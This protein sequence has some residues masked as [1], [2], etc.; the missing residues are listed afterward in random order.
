MARRKLMSLFA[1]LACVAIIAGYP[2]VCLSQPSTHA[3]APAPVLSLGAHTWAL[4][5]GISKYS[6]PMISGLTS[7]ARDVA[8]IAASLEDP[9]L[10][11]VPSS[12][13]LI[14]T[15]EN[16]TGQR[17][18]GAA[19]TFFKPNVKPGDQ[20]ILYLAGHG[21]A[22]GIGETAK[23]YLLPYDVKGL[24]KQA[25][26]ESAVNLREFNDRLAQLPASQFVTFVDACRED[27]TPG[28]G[29][30]GNVLSDT[31]TDQMQIQ[32]RPDASGKTASAVTF[33]ACSVGERAY[34]DPQMEHGVFTYFI[35]DAIKRAAVPQ[36]PDG[37]VDMGRLGTYVTEHVDSW[38]KQESASGD[39]DVEQNPQLVTSDLAQPVVLM[40]VR[41]P[42]PA[43][44]VSAGQP[45]LIV[46]TS[47]AEAT[48]TVNG[49][50]VGSGD[51]Q[52]VI[53]DAGQATVEVSASGY[54]LVR[55]TVNAFAGYGSELS[56]T[57]PPASRGLTAANDPAATTGAV[58]AAYTQAVDAAARGQWDVAE[59]GYRD[60]IKTSPHFAPA[61]EQLAEV[62]RGQNRIGEC[63]GTLILLS[64]AAPSTAHRLSELSMAFSQYAGKGPG[65]STDAES[66]GVATWD[67]HYTTSQREAGLLAMKAA[68]SAVRADSH[69][70][71][72]ER[73]L[74]FALVATD[75]RGSN[76]GDSLNAFRS[77]VF[78]DPAD[79]VNHMALAFGMRNFSRFI[80]NQQERTGE[81][82]RAVEE[83]KQ[84]VQ[85][86]PN[87]Y[88]AHRELA[89]CYHLLKNRRAAE[90]EYVRACANSGH[91]IDGNEVAGA[92]CA[93]AILTKQDAADAPEGRKEA[94]EEASHG[95]W[96]SATDV[97]PDLKNALLS[98]LGA[99]LVNEI[100]N[101][102][103][104]VLLA[105]KE[106]QA[107]L[108]KATDDFLIA[109]G[110]STGSSG[111]TGAGHDTS[112]WEPR[113][114]TV[115][116]VQPRTKADENDTVQASP[117]V[118]IP[119]KFGA[120]ALVLMIVLTMLTGMWYAGARAAEF[121][122]KNALQ[123]AGPG[124]R[125]SL[126]GLFARAPKETPKDTAE[127]KQLRRR[128]F[129][130]SAT[131]KGM[132]DAFLATDLRGNVTQMNPLAEKITGWQESEAIGK[133]IAQVVLIGQDQSG[134]A[135]EIPLSEALH[136]NIEKELTPG[137]TV[138]SRIGSRKVVGG[139]V[140]P[141]W[142][143]A[144]AVTGAALIFQERTSFRE[145]QSYKE[146]LVENAL[147]CIVAMDHRGI[148]V[149]FN[150]A[151][152]STF[153]YTRAEAVGR[154]V[155]DILIPPAMRERHEFGLEQY[156]RTRKA[157]ILG[158][159]I[160]MV[161]QRKGG[162][163]II[164]EMSIAEVPGK[165]PPV[166]ICS[167]R[168][169]TA[170]KEAEEALLTLSAQVRETL[171][172][173]H[174]AKSKLLNV[175]SDELRTPLNA[176]IGYSEILE[177]EL[178]ERRPDDMLPDLKK[179]RGAGSHMLTLTKD[180]LDLSRIEAGLF[181]VNPEQFDAGE[182]V[183]G[184]ASDLKVIAESNENRLE[185]S[186]ADDLGVMHS[187]RMLIR[188]CLFYLTH[189]ACKFATQRDLELTASRNGSTVNFALRDLTPGLPEGVEDLDLDQTPNIRFA[190]RGIGMVITRE[191]CKLLGGE[192][193]AERI[194]GG[195]PVY[196][197]ALPDKV[198]ERQ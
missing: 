7:P 188:Q 80:K 127:L 84:A 47:P 26:E 85:I 181:P 70:A 117:Q 38:A 106:V 153:Q 163:E 137:T 91:A 194:P 39:F 37:A 62:L 46:S 4:L 22:K 111:S 160:E 130:L 164:V 83:L 1:L 126:A 183:A 58:P 55:K 75:N 19:D 2:S 168:E 94:L 119:V 77:A 136:G 109:T 128:M 24:S 74:G 150:T 98:L 23:G 184:V 196:T 96:A 40:H 193:L 92:M 145:N 9:K 133:P 29:V 87:F 49:K 82:E 17:I 179:I 78:L 141:I 107:M 88:A 103:P 156:L 149:D 192:L 10:G 165:T 115:Y 105:S 116:V 197:L 174:V 51:V 81:V 15:N 67:F 99:G 172:S 6:S 97:C 14:L 121:R 154:R 43:A 151:A 101:F 114:E 69:L 41:R 33:F 50:V 113:V 32:P 34:E 61:Y 42:L 68:I 60:A 16:A 28:R 102:I 143:D 13:V 129:L 146:T 148:I 122:A 157:T 134:E 118:V 195:S 65:A 132:S 76:K 155:S 123:D 71:E 185:V 190:G 95:Y 90:A 162:Q 54:A 120:I 72:A 79:P 3:E 139:R 73:A 173:E 18:K 177:D 161:A 124:A 59:A 187:D 20:I 56:V 131:M 63:L 89:Y 25:L 27:P 142:D 171:H 158:K 35:L 189:N 52:A 5:V 135:H 159:K 48:V 170:S 31:V 93:L 64:G 191:F 186:I 175:L 180:I 45:R 176:I 178:H 8:A 11:G 147:E 110:L 138:V 166:F 21:V 104:Q 182:L 86:R 144:G 44:T 167:L 53:E 108:A 100:K 169:I 36:K 30:K 12:H 140:V 198:E 66:A 57:L 152:E 125:F 112:E